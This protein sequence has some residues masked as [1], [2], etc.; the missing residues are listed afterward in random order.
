ML[1]AAQICSPLGHTLPSVAAVLPG[2]A[3]LR[4]PH[5]GCVFAAEPGAEGPSALRLCH[6][7]RW[8]DA[9]GPDVGGGSVC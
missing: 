8:D 3:W 9:S 1:P 5:A 7:P 4:N 2:V 6:P